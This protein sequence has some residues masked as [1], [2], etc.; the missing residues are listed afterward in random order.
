MTAALYLA[1]GA[2]VVR[3]P[4]DEHGYLV[5]TRAPLLRPPHLVLLSESRQRA[6]ISKKGRGS[7]K[8][9]AAQAKG[10]RLGESSAVHTYGTVTLSRAGV[11]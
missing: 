3:R 9:G 1:S 8:K 7:K 5:R 4:G 11:D 6:A 2:Q 10:R